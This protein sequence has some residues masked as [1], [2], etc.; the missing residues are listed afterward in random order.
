MN[1][2]QIAQTQNSAVLLQNP[3]GIA[4][5]LQLTNTAKKKKVKW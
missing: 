4:I 1:E 3:I 5:V 2:L